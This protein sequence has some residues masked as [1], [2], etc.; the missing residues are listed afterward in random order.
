MFPR[1]AGVATAVPR[2]ELDQAEIAAT[3]HGVFK[4]RAEVFERMRPVYANAGIARRYSC[5][6]LDW[7]TRPHGWRERHDLFVE[8]AL[9]LLQRAALDC[10]DQTGVA[11]EAID[12]IAVVS[13]TGMTTPSL[14]ARLMERM[15]FRR[16]VQRLPLFGFGCAGGVIGLSRTAALVKASPGQRWLFLVV[17]LCGLTFRSDDQSNSNIVATALFGDG[18]AA[19][20]VSVESDGPAVIGWGEH[21]WPDS[22][23]VM[24]WRVEDDGFGVQFSRDIPSLVRREFGAA[25]D[26]FLETQGVSLADIGAFVLHPGG[27][28]VMDALQAALGVSPE[29]LQASRDVLRDF[30]NMSAATVMFVYRQALSGAPPGLIL[31]GALG[32]GFTAGFALLDN[33]R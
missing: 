2:F 17:E 23:E 8:N 20:L 15:P 10:L 12:G 19:A 21:T 9:D 11:P 25:A 5:V 3:A 13:T 33:D 26:R 1:L 30:G 32:P 4:G 29:A 14:D 24:G 31:I 22:L 7:Y 6:P 27:V 28:K 18:A 16:D